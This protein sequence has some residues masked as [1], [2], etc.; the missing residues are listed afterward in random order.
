MFE[1]AT[2]G[3]RPTFGPSPHV[4]RPQ[5]GPLD[6]AY[7]SSHP[8]SRKFAIFLM[9]AA[10]RAETTCFQVRGVPVTLL[11]CLQKSVTPC[12]QSRRDILNSTGSPPCR[13]RPGPVPQGTQGPQASTKSTAPRG[14][15]RPL[16][17]KLIHDL[18]PLRLLMTALIP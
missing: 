10:T 17:S 9:L 18:V 15:I 1:P 13:L 7:P 16:A 5:T 8:K 4:L 12:D 2:S 14:F 3:I 6:S 11:R